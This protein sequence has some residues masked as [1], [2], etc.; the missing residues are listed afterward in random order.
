MVGGDNA[1]D[2]SE[3]FC[4]ESGERFSGEEHFES[5]F[6]GEWA[7][8]WDCGGGAEDSDLDSWRREGGGLGSNDEIATCG[9][10][11]SLQLL[12][13]LPPERSPVGDLL[14]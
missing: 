2:H 6:R 14:D 12:R 11:G 10:L 3:A 13:G 4:V 9:E 1:V 5:F 8:E 7:T